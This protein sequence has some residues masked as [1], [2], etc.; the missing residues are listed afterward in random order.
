M[1]KRRKCLAIFRL[2]KLKNVDQ[3]KKEG[4][5]KLEKTFPWILGFQRRRRLED[6]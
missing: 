4:C 2:N 6:K 3:F 1:K 5:W